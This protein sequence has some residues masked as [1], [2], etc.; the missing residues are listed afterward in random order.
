MKKILLIMICLLMFGCSSGSA[1][2]LDYNAA[3]KAMDEKY[4]GMVTVDDTQLEVIYGLDLKLLGEHTVK[5][6]GDNNGDMYII[7][8]TEGSNKSEVKSQMSDMFD[9]LKT[10]NGM[11]T[12]EVIKLI[13]N[14]FETSVGDYLIYLVGS[15]T[16]AMYS[17]IKDSIK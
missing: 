10:Q 4:P 2:N 1:N 9:V 11:Y 12:P 17:V 16:Q 13:D 8:K 3:V 14:R 7:L 15:D 6:S 5:Y